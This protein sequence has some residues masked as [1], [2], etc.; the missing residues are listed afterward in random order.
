MT[1]PDTV[2]LFLDRYVVPGERRSC[3]KQLTEAA[4][5]LGLKDKVEVRLKPRSS[6]YMKSFAIPED[7]ELV[8]ALKTVLLK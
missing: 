2:L 4:D 8:L 3:L 1:V 7:H 5:K 6:P